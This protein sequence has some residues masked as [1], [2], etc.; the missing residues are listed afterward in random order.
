MR[1]GLLENISVD[2]DVGGGGGVGAEGRGRV[3]RKKK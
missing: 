3:A 1:E 2:G